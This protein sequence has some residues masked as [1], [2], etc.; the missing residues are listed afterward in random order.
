MEIYLSPVDAEHVINISRDFGIDA[1]VVGRVETSDKKE[2]VIRAE[3]GE[4]RYE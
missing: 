2:L 3:N 4:W 1:Q